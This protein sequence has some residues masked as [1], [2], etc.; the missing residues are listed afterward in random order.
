MIDN[1]YS[2]LLTPACFTAFGLGALLAYYKIHQPEYGVKFQKTV[3][4]L[5]LLSLS[6]LIVQLATD[7]SLIL[8]Q[9]LFISLMSLWLIS[10]YV[11]DNKLTKIDA[12][13]SK[14]YLIYIGKISYGMYLFHTFIPSFTKKAFT[15][16][17][18]DV[19][20]A[21]SY[22]QGSYSELNLFLYNVFNF[23]VLLLVATLSWYII[24]KTLNNLKRYFV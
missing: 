1:Q 10:N 22:E 6:A 11:F 19:T 15:K 17:G 16:L 4:I 13:F 14:T 20:S 7:I 23:L 21:I 3:S 12:F 18:V 8:P 9:R 2:S 5:A 24:E